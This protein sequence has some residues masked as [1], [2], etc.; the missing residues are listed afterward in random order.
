MK[1]HRSKDRECKQGNEKK[2][3]KHFNDVE[4]IVTILYDAYVSA[5]YDHGSKAFGTCMKEYVD[6]KKVVSYGHFGTCENLE[7][8]SWE[9][10]VK[11]AENTREQTEVVLLE[12]KKSGLKDSG[13]GYFQAISFLKVH[14]SHFMLENKY[15]TVQ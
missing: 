15:S 14:L 8:M 13:W 12:V 1:S 11:R 2:K 7:K 5:G 10:H 4:N 3:K 9:M 6:W